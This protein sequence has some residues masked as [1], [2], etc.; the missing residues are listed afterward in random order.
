MKIQ[1]MSDLH[2]EFGSKFTFEKRKDTILVLAGDIHSDMGELKN[3]VTYACKNYAHVIMVAGNHEHYGGEYFDTLRTIKSFGFNLLNF[4]FLENETVTL[5]GTVFIGATLWSQPS[6]ATF[7]RI[8]DGQYIKFNASGRRLATCE[9]HPYITNNNV[10]DLNKY[11]SEYIKHTLSEMTEAEDDSPVCLITHFG[12]D[13]SLCGPEWEGNSLNDYFWAKGFG[14]Y[15]HKADFWLF[16]HT[17]S[18]VDTTIDSCRFICNPY[19]Y[20][21]CAVN[22]NFIFDLEV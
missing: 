10:F 19:G 5:A 9:Q 18:S 4:H 15:V 13:E 21:N 14:E 7:E 3:F 17:H 1:L 12:P 8:S 11:S 6:F 2:L 20:E 16:G 22:R